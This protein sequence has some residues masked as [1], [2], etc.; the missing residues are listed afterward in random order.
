MILPV[1][2]LWEQ[3]DGPQIKA[4]EEATFEYFKQMLDPK[5]DYLDNLSVETANDAHLT[6]LG[7]LANFVRPVITVPD[8][9]FFFLTEDVEHNSSHGFSSIGDRTVGGRLTEVAGA[10]TEA[11]PLNTEHY[12]LLLKAYIENEGELGGLKLLDDI[13]YELSKLD[14]PSITPFYRFE[15]MEGDNIPKGRGPGDVYIDIG[16]LDNWNNPMQVYAILRGLAKSTYWPV[17]Q[18]FISIDTIITVPN[19]TSSLPSGTY[20][21]P[22][23]VELSCSMS[24]AVIHYTLDGGT[25]TSDSPVYVPGSPITIRESTLL[26]VRALAP[27]YN[28]SNIV[29]FNYIIK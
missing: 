14:Q 16:S 2:F 4:I 7:I 26:R 20:S 15:F 29:E 23:D 17:P 8:K 11:R 1:K 22:Q 5:L 27:S 21:G 28:N 18:L 13:C 19:P 25:P 24:S 3:L 6:F 9:D 10:S 12:R